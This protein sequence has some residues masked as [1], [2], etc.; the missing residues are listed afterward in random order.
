M[1]A[2]APPHRV[3]D[4]FLDQA[5]ADGLLAQILAAAPRFEP[6]KIGPGAEASVVSTYRS[7]LRLPGRVG[8][9]LQPF[10][11]AE[12]VDALLG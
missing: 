12:F 1:M 8:V 4:D 9:D 5:T 6:A 7:A 3:I 11:A 10:V 2:L